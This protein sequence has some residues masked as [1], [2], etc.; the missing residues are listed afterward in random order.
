M[1]LSL[2]NL[3]LS[4]LLKNIF[5]NA[6]FSEA[7]V[8]YKAIT[9]GVSRPISIRM[10]KIASPLSGSPRYGAANQHTHVTTKV[11]VKNRIGL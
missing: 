10:R 5:F 11:S 1:L 2:I 7:I 8:M 4:N 9:N 3:I 6:S